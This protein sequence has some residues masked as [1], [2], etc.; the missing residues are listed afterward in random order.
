MF[1]RLTSHD[2]IPRTEEGMRD[3]KRSTGATVTHLLVLLGEHAK[4]EVVDDLPGEGN[5]LPRNFR[6]Q[7]QRYYTG[8]K[9]FHE[10]LGLSDLTLDQER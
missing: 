7:A 2:F 6:E 8:R 4:S 9:A 5:I 10:Y 3:A 1:T